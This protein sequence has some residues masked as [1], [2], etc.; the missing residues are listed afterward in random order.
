MKFF[1][2]LQTFFSESGSYEHQKV[3]IYKLKLPTKFG[4]VSQ[5]RLS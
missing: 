5:N 3:M 4:F 2:V 1:F